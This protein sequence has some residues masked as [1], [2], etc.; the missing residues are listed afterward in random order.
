MSNSER[1]PYPFSRR[2]FIK[3]AAAVAASGALAGCSPQAADT[4]DAQPPAADSET[5]HFAGVCRCGCAGHCFLDV[6]V[7]DGQV[8]RTTAGEMC[9]PRYNRICSKG[10]SHVGRVYSAK[11]LQYPMKRTGERGE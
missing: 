3:G 5:Q 6:H 11:R 2:S 8:V 7:R 1:K 10:L 9:D 4:E